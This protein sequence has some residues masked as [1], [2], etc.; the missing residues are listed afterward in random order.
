MPCQT[1]LSRAR[2]ATTCALTMAAL[3]PL[4]RVLLGALISILTV[5]VVLLTSTS[6]SHDLARKY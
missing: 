3:P 6:R 4:F 1:V 2:C 5:A